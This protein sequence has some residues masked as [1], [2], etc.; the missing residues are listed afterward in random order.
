MFMAGSKFLF[1]VF[2]L[3]SGIAFT[4]FF[5]MLSY[6]LFLPV[7]TQTGFLIG[8]IIG[9]A[10]LGVGIAIVTYKFSRAFIVQILAGV[11]GGV[12]IFMV[13][14]PMHLKF[15]PHLI[16]MLVGVGAGV[17]L[18]Q[19]LKTFVKAASTALI[20]SFLFVWGIGCY[21]PGFPSDFAEVDIKNVKDLDNLVWAYFAGFVVCA[22]FGTWFQ[23]RH[24]KEDADKFD[25]MNNEDEGKVC[26]CL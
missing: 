2:G 13:T 20:G 7:D 12:I 22:V 8:T 19:Q 5:F 9:C 25:E 26:G 18:G 23:L 24:F 4:G 15:W 10:V 11:T 21:A 17:F 16:L 6:A 1:Q 3:I 14:K